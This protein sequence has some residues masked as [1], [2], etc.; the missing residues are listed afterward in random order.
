MNNGDFEVDILDINGQ[1]VGRKLRKDI[2]KGADIY[3]AVYGVV[4]T[5]GDEIVISVIGNPK[6]LPNLHAGKLGCTCAT[7][8]RTGETAEQAMTR[9]IADELKINMLPKL[10]SESFIDIDNTKRLISFYLIESD[11]PTN[12]SKEDIEELKK[13]TKKEFQE[14]LTSEPEKLTPPLKLFWQEYSK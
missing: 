12:Y 5:P 7:I 3:H 8:R 1:V 4:V 10:L 2:V 13:F 11:M 14:L 9:A 6:D